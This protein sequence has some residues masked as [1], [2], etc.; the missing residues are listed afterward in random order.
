MPEYP[1]F[2]LKIDR[3]WEL[4]IYVN[5]RGD[6]YTTMGVTFGVLDL[7]TFRV[8]NRGPKV[9]S[10]TLDKILKILNSIK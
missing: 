3:R 4:Y 7:S 5:E 2:R 10:R 8:Y 6:V 1:L 9:T